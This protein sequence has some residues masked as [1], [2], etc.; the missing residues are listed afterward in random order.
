VTNSR[1]GGRLEDHRPALKEFEASLR[2]EPGRFRG[3]YGAAKA[4]QLSGDRK[5][6]ENYYTKL[7]ALCRQETGNA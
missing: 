1:P 6:A 4:A 3:F 7:L 2:I 5:K